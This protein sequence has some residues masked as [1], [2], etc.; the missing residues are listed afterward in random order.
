MKNQDNI[1]DKV[2]ETFRIIGQRPLMILPNDYS[3]HLLQN[4]IEGYIDGL[5]QTYDLNL[6]SMI[7][8][9]YSKK[10]GVQTSYYWSAH[11]PF[12]FE[13]KN[14]DELKVILIDITVNFFKENPDWF[15]AGN[16]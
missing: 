9:W 3:Y 8:R 13:G 4:Y 7:T 2:L 10:V 11:I 5:S 1:N 14:D 6:R 12:H 16:R 15:E